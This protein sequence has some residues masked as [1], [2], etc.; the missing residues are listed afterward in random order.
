MASAGTRVIVV[1]PAEDH[2]EPWALL[3][4]GAADLVLW[5]SDPRPVLAR[6]ERLHEVERLVTGPEVSDQLLSRIGSRPR[7]CSTA[8]TARNSGRPRRARSING[9][10]TAAI[11]SR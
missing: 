2:P 1:A 9:P 5:Q 8:G 6:L 7:V 11:G 3:A 4:S 10:L